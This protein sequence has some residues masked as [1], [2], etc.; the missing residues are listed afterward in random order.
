MTTV[1]Y[2]KII[3]LLAISLGILTM[4]ACATPEFHS[5][6]EIHP[7]DPHAPPGHMQS[8]DTLSQPEAVNTEPAHSRHWDRDQGGHPEHNHHG[9]VADDQMENLESKQE[10]NHDMQ[11][12]AHQHK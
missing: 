8:S 6:P 9:A 5:L 7:A 11:H 12:E 10:K 3:L 2:S 1:K 4:G